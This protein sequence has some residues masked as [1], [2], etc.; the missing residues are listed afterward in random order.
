MNACST[1]LV[2]EAYNAPGAWWLSYAWCGR[3]LMDTTNIIMYNY[4][5]W[6]H[7]MPHAP[8]AWECMTG[9]MNRVRGAFHKWEHLFWDTQPWEQGS[10]PDV[11]T[12]TSKSKTRPK[13]IGPGLHNQLKLTPLSQ[14]CS[15]NTHSSKSGHLQ[16]NLPGRQM[17]FSWCRQEYPSIRHTAETV[18]ILR[19][20]LLHHYLTQV[21]DVAESHLETFVL[22][23]GIF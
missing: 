15:L 21:R 13:T 5:F 9:L 23:Y 20:L 14:Q 10:E 22:D 16:P 19:L 1:H 4:I 17:P 6:L 3:H 2:L 18:W 7:E 11:K 12:Q 8:G